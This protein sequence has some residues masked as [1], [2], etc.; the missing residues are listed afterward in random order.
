MQLV[1][2]PPTTVT[3]SSL[4][5]YAKASEMRKNKTNNEIYFFMTVK[6][7]LGIKIKLLR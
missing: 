5:L 7:R 3:S 6:N 4:S 1:I 2:T